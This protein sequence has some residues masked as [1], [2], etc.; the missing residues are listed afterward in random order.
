MIRNALKT[1]KGNLLY[2]VVGSLLTG[3]IVGQFIGGDTRETLRLLVIPALFVM[4]YPM[5]VNIDLSRVVSASEHARSVGLSVL[6][7]FVIS[8]VFAVGLVHLFFNGDAGYAFGLY[9][10]ALIP[11]SGMTAAWTGLAGGDLEAALV[12]L[13]LNLLVA[14]L[15]LPLYLSVLVGGAEL[16]DPVALYRQ[17]AIV[18]IVPMVAGN[19]TRR[20]LHRRYQPA[21][22]RDLKPIFGGVSSV[23]VMLIVFIATAMQSTAILSQPLVSAGMI[24]PLVIFYALI[25]STSALIGRYLLTTA[26]SIA[27]IYATSM[28]NLSIALA[29]VVA[30]DSIPTE[31]VLPIALGY[32]IQPPLGALYRQYRVDVIDGGRSP[33][34]LI[35]S[36]LPVP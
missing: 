27:L 5:M 21:G 15:V 14:V 18:V 25:M 29:I 13:A 20:Y 7:N 9:M 22:F 36:K 28:R 31:A 6:V 4:V 1:L 12:A 30:A 19:I 2:A 33:R 32:L 35:R 17:L 10:I 3:L 34:E 16:F 26:Q 23:G 24:V 11:T 8:P